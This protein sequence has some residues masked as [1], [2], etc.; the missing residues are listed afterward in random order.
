MYDVKCLTLL[1]LMM[2]DMNV[3]ELCINV[4]VLDWDDD[5]IMMWLIDDNVFIVRDAWTRGRY[6]DEHANVN[7][8]DVVER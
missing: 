7:I 4:W 5:K 6:D 2:K 1:V 3:L 8:N